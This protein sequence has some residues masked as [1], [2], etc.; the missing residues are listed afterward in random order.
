MRDMIKYD[1]TT[2]EYSF[3][4][5]HK[6]RTD[7]RSDDDKEVN[8][9]GYLDRML[10]ATPIYAYDPDGPIEK[11]NR[12]ITRKAFLNAIANEVSKMPDDVLENFL[13]DPYTLFNYLIDKYT[14]DINTLTQLNDVNS[15]MMYSFI[16]H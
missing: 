3:N 4:I 6:I 8:I 11:S 13:R 1:H 9:N 14:N 15:I 7:Y 5:A 16:Q 12:I 2:G 10:E